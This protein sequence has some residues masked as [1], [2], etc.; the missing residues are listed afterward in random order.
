[1][2][3]RIV[4][5]PLRFSRIDSLFPSR[6]VCLNRSDAPHCQ[7]HEHGFGEAGAR[8]SGWLR[9]PPPGRGEGGPP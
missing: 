2:R 3:S 9:L 5:V 1:M 7:F 4:H 8:W 6:G